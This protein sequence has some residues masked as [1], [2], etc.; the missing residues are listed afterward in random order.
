MRVLLEITKFWIDDP[1]DQIYLLP[2]ILLAV[3]IVVVALYFMRS[4]EIR[5]RR[6]W[7]SFLKQV[8]E[9]KL[10]QHEIKTVKIFFE[11]VPMKDRD[12]IL[13]NREALQREL[14]NFFNDIT[15]GMG[16]G[17]YKKHI[18][19]M[20]KLFLSKKESVEIKTLEDLIPGEISALS[21]D[22]EHRL[23]RVHA[24]REN[25]ILVSIRD[26]TPHKNQ[27]GEYTELVAYRPGVGFHTIP[28]RIQA[29]GKNG[30][31]LSQTDPI[32]VETEEQLV[33]L[34]Q[35]D[36]Q[37]RPL[38][39]VQEM[40]NV[41]GAVGNSQEE[42]ENPPEEIILHGYTI[43]ISEK[44]AL[45]HMDEESLSEYDRKQEHWEMTVTIDEY[46]PFMVSGSLFP[47][48]GARDRFLLKFFE[49]NEEQKS[50]IFW[51]IKNYTPVREKLI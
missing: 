36:V 38:K 27:A 50:Y 12:R 42:N 33:S 26:Y 48:P 34:A 25:A 20:S 28:V 21:L 6:Q 16:E 49:L 32:K 2:F 10:S 8:L 4:N 5:T 17:N 15:H 1:L 40:E 51:L 24:I 30:Y 3:L 47:V 43:K 9:K 13:F 18:H 46:T 11:S 44:A 7:A 35:F 41:A 31:R 22:R 37:F 45:V 29:V 19:I 39:T 23:V 14:Y